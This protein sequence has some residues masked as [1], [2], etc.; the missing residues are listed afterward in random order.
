LAADNLYDTACE[1]NFCHTQAAKFKLFWH[2]ASNG[3]GSG[4]AAVYISISGKS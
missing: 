2:N 1:V 4:C 3:M